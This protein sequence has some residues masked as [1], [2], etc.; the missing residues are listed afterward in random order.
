M[1]FRVQAQL[2][3]AFGPLNRWYCSQAYGY[4]VDDPERLL[5]YFIKSGGAADFESRYAEAMGAKNRWY[6]SEYY[7]RD[8]RDEETLRNYFVNHPPVQSSNHS[9][10]NS[11]EQAHR[12]MRQGERVL[13]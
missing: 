12:K 8:I 7:G 4:R 11:G 6:C 3:E 10:D 9:R 5:I 2:S 13:A 1:V